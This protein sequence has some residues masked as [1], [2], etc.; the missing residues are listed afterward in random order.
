LR[1]ATALRILALALHAPAAI[2]SEKNK[3]RLWSD[4]SDRRRGEASALAW[5]LMPRALNSR[6]GK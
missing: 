1:L 5:L 6:A 4:I 2:R 3:R